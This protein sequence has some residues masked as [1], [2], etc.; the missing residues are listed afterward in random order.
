[1]KAKIW[2]S[3]SSSRRVFSGVPQVSVLGPFFFI[4]YINFVVSSL[5]CKFKIFADD[6]KLYL[7]FDSMSPTSDDFSI[8]QT[9]NDQLVKS[10]AAWGTW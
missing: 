3:L 2:S 4:G 9:K 1:M 7:T 6:I 10:S 5:S 8:L